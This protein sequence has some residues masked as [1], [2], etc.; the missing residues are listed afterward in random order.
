[1]L[2]HPATHLLSGQQDSFLL[3]IDILDV[4]D[5]APAQSGALLEPISQIG[6]SRILQG[7]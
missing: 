2:W 4:S 6:K 1:V 5:K 7:F 3:S